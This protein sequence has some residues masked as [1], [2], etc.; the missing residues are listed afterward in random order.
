MIGNRSSLAR[1]QT[2]PLCMRRIHWGKLLA[3]GCTGAV[4][5]LATAAF[6]PAMAAERE[7]PNTLILDDPTVGDE[8]TLPQFVW[9]PDVG[10]NT[11]QVQ[12]E[13]SK[14]ITPTTALIFAQG[15]D[16]LQQKGA[17]THS[18]LENA[19]LNAKWQA[20]T[21]PDHEFV[22]SLGIIREFNGNASTVNIGGDPYGATSPTVFFGKGLGDLPIGLLRPLAITGQLSY[23][24]P[25]RRLNQDGT[26]NGSPFTWEGGFSVQYSIPYLQS[27]VKDFG[28]PTFIGNLTPLVEVSFLT[29]AFGPAPNNPMQLLI[30]PGVIYSG[31]AFQIGAEAL[32]PANSAT[33]HGV[34]AIFKLH[35]FFDELFP[36]SLL[37]KPVV[38][39]F[40]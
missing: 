8:A 13:Y 32:I 37:G 31:K 33:G 18:G 40:D 6:V 15:F 28:L 25:D 23:N 22:L 11:Y 17:E 26:N 9:Q 5:T 3:L 29:P 21:I 24:I 16:V 30:A 36:N 4:L 12:W 2:A 20:L 38:D 14:T 34:G 1:A 19:R 7:F 35:F 27:E 39:W 10:Q